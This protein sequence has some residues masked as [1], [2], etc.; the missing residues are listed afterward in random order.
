M[1]GIWPNKVKENRRAIIVGINKYELD[2]KIQTLAGAENDA[3]EIAERLKNNG[4]FEIS[5][6]HLLLGPDATRAKILKAVDDIFRREGN[7]DLVTFYFSGH[8]MV[9]ENNEGYIV[10]YDMDPVY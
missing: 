7:H 2:S 9:D 1:S 8:S 4:D 10:P 3:K 5:D 6:N